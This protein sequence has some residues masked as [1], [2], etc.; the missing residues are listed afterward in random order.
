MRKDMIAIDGSKQSQIPELEFVEKFWTDRWESVAAEARNNQI[1]QRDEY[2]I[3]SPYLDKLP[4]GAAIVDGGC[5]LGEWTILL[6]EN[7]FDAHGL[8][9]S[10]TTC[11]RLQE[12][13]PEYHFECCDIRKTNYANDSFDFYFSW[14]AFEHFEEGLNPCFKEAHRILKPGRHLAVTVPYYNARLLAKDR[15]VQNDNNTQNQRFYQWR[16]TAAELRAEFEKAGFMLVEE[17]LIHKHVGASR[18]AH[19]LGLNEGSILHAIVAGLA[20]RLLSATYLSHMIIGV[21]VKQ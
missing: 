11:A 5:G 17:H 10:K 9:I 19:G 7:G 16:L 2:K 8:D 14:G 3:I 18:C 1:I 15:D 12:K 21:G 20:R 4:R 13:F 6:G